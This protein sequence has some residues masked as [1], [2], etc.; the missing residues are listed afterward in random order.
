MC[1]IVKKIVEWNYFNMEVSFLNKNKIYS[2]EYFVMFPVYSS[3]GD[4]NIF[5]GKMG[6]LA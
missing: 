3:V 1:K 5:G 4:K 2:T 6:S